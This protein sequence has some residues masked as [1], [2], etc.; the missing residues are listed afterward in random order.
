MQLAV[1]EFARNIC[2]L[3]E[4][5]SEEFDS[6]AKVQMVKYL[7]GQNEAVDMGGTLRLGDYKAYLE[8]QTKITEIY[9]GDIANERHR[10]R[11]EINP[12]YHQI[13]KENGLSL[14]G[15]SKDKKLIEFISLET[16]PYF[17]GTQGHPE[18][19]S[20]LEKPAPLFLGLAKAAI[21]RKDSVND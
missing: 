5:T 16:H 20:K 7:P 10:H 8:G 4:A 1:L 9:E 15:L 11:Y 21:K 3:K 2:N 13:L 12:D 14:A 17:V 18:L 6:S 19:K